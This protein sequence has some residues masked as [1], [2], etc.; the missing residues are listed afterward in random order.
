MR[1]GKALQQVQQLV[2]EATSKVSD[3]GEPTGPVL[4]VYEGERASIYYEGDM[5]RPK[6]IGRIS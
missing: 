3:G 2:K 4:V 1:T 5:P 6:A